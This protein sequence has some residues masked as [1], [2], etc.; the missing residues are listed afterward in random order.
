MDDDDGVEETKKEIE[1]II[2]NENLI[3]NIEDPFQLHPLA[4]VFEFPSVNITTNCKIYTHL[5]PLQNSKYWSGYPNEWHAENPDHI[6]MKRYCLN[7]V[8]QQWSSLWRC[9]LDDIKYFIKFN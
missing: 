1:K 6:S 4:A 5:Y 9:H 2:N 8:A 7:L 3:G